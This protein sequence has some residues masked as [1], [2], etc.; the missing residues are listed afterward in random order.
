MNVAYS[1]EEMIS[2]TDM[3]KNF[4]KTLEKVST[5]KIEKI[6]IMKNNKP[7]AILE[8]IAEGKMRKFFEENTLLNQPV[9]G[10]KETIAEFI[11]K[12]DKE[13]TVVAYKRFALGE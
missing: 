11:H 7:E 3:L 6:A 2:T 1:R 4:A 13:A 9:V 10:E 5:H 8:K 12:A